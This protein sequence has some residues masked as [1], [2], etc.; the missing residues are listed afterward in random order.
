MLLSSRF[1]KDQT[2]KG[3]L[4]LWSVGLSITMGRLG[5]DSPAY[6][7]EN[8]RHG[9]PSIAKL[10]MLVSASELGAAVVRGSFLL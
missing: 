1:R 2:I 6:A 5:H 10:M 9:C 7:N 3:M 8:R 4:S